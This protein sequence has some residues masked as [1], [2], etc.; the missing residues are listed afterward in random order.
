MEVRQKANDL[1]LEVDAALKA[2]GK[3]VDKHEKRQIRA[4]MAELQRVLARRPGKK[5]K[6]DPEAEARNI[7]VAAAKLDQ[8]SANVR[9]QFGSG[10]AANT[11]GGSVN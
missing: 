7:V 2:G 3:Q 1:L 4:D 8:S 6:A 5:E 11:E 10:E 9:Q